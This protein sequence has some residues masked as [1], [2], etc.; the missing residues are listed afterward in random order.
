MCAL[1][2]RKK[3]EAKVLASCRHAVM[4]D[5]SIQ[6]FEDQVLELDLHRRTRMHLEGDDAV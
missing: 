4:T 5:A 2:L 1:T 3:E 6:F